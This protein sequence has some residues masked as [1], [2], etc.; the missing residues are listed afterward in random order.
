MNKHTIT[1]LDITQ[2]YCIS[3]FG[4]VILNY[5]HAVM[6][7]KRSVQQKL[8]VK[9]GTDV[10]ISSVPNLMKTGLVLFTMR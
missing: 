2:Y 4:E 8:I 6:I 1:Q 9:C 5:S 7:S 10:N 3:K